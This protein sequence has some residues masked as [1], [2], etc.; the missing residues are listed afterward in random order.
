MKWSRLWAR[1]YGVHYSE[2][3]VRFLGDLVKDISPITTNDT[4]MVPEDGREAYYIPTEDFNRFMGIIIKEYCKDLE[5]FKKLEQ[6][7][8][9]F[10][11]AFLKTTEKIKAMDL[12]KKS[13]EELAALFDEYWMSIL[14]YNNTVFIT[15][16]MSEYTAERANDIIVRRVKER[17]KQD[18]ILQAVLTPFKKASIMK[19]RDEISKGKD[20]KT[21]YGNY[22]WMPCIDFIFSPWTKEQ[23]LDAV[24][25]LG[26][27]EKRHA[28][29]TDVLKEIKLTKKEGE[30]LRIANLGAYIKD[31]RDEYRRKGF[32]NISESL[33]AE[34]SKR[35]GVSVKNIGFLI[36]DDIMA[37][38]K[39][40]KPDLKKIEERK[41]GFLIYMKGGKAVCASGKDIQ[42]AMKELGIEQKQEGGAGEIKGMIANRGKAQGTVKIV[43][44]AK[45]I[46]KVEKGD[47]LVASST[48]PDYITA[49]QR[50]AAFVTDEGGLTS[51]AAIVAREMGKPCIVGTKNATNR[52][53]DGDKIEVDANKGIIRKL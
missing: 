35:I 33:I 37:A 3:C 22:R 18:R 11:S 13:N 17:G 5:S 24:R 46:E 29:L 53:K 9:K 45:D 20:P 27:E 32:C 44:R 14:R 52:L 31:K 41:K 21:L 42:K 23:F 12:R 2:L 7:M 16:N 43:K 1:E 15:F 8:H 51:H 36:K 6:R 30:L 48:H 34:I 50:A 25:E 49:M 26:K 19:L 47:M 38:L 28:K 4:A 10:G 39:G 40:K